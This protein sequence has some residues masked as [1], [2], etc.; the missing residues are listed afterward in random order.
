[1]NGLREIHGCLPPSLPYHLHCP[2]LAMCGSHVAAVSCSRA[3]CG[4]VREPLTGGMWQSSLCH[5][6]GLLCQLIVPG[7]QQR[8]GGREGEW[9]DVWQEASGPS[10]MFVGRL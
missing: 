7:L 4:G 2:P 8:E 6:R 5:C 10:Q 9:E 3:C 1:M